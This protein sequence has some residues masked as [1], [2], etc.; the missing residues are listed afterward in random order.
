[1]HDLDCCLSRY[2]DPAFR[3]AVE[4][5]FSLMESPVSDVINYQKLQTACCQVLDVLTD[6]TYLPLIE[7]IPPTSLENMFK[8]VS[9][10]LKNPDS[11]IAGTCASIID[12]LATF[13]YTERRKARQLKHFLVDFLDSRPDILPF[14][15]LQL[16]QSVLLEDSS[17]QW[18][19]SRPLL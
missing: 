3:I 1:M 10:T 6:G 8:V 12:H 13:V 18:S 9:E 15:L 4:A 5:T 7:A 16:L 2:N 19:L 14:I 17:I 11:P